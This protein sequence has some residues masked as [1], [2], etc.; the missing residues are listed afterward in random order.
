MLWAKPCGG[1]RQ[2]GLR[3]RSGQGRWAWWGQGQEAKTQGRGAARPPHGFSGVLQLRG[4][5]GKDMCP[6][7]KV[8]TTM[9]AAVVTVT[10]VMAVAVVLRSRLLTQTL[11]P[12]GAAGKGI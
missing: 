10:V 11:C 2:P 3:Q 7:S 12:K 5:A 4:R 8:S 1:D 9:A 6:C